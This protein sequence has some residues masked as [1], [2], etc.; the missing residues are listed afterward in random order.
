M[1]QIYFDSAYEGVTRTG[2]ESQPYLDPSELPAPWT[3]AGGNAYF[4]KRGSEWNFTQSFKL[5]AFTTSAISIGAYGDES[6]QRPIIRCYRLIDSSEC[7]EVSLSFTIGVA[8]MTTT[9]ASGTNLWRVPASFLGLFEGD[10]WGVAVDPT[11]TIIGGG[12]DVAPAAAREYT[13]LNTDTNT[14]RVV[15]SE[16]NPV[17]VYGGLYAS[18]MSLADS[19]NWEASRSIYVVNAGGGCP[20]SDI[21][22]DL[23]RAPIRFY[24]ALTTDT[25]N[26]KRM[27]DNNIIDCVLTRAAIGFEYACDDTVIGSG[28]GFERVRVRGNYGENLGRSFIDTSSSS[29]S[30]C[31]NDTRIYENVCNGFGQSYSTGG[32]YLARVNTT[33]G[34]HVMVD[35]NTMSGGISGN[36]WPE[37]GHAFYQEIDSQDLMFRDNFSWNNDQNFI[38][39]IGG[40]RVAFVANVAVAKANTFDDLSRMFTHT[41]MKAESNTLFHGNVAVGLKN[42]VTSYDLGRIARSAVI[43]GNVSL[44]DVA[45]GGSGLTVNTNALRFGGH[46]TT[47]VT[48]DGNALSGHDNSWFDTTAW[49]AYNTAPQ[50][51]NPVAGDFSAEVARIPVPTDPTVNYALQI[52]PGARIVNGTVDL[53]PGTRLVV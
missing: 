21:Q 46:D 38:C 16:G 8:A 15:Y 30:I 27:P 20:V 43:S 47:Y 9:P 53:R 50:I 32:I 19:V 7:T 1:A 25:I 3:I 18:N 41:S 29:G 37:D 40:R 52:R 42:L 22:F 36:I 12:D 13:S 6:S 23:C 34:S 5:A 2:S 51:N 4:F 44:C 26:Y 35:R 33:D 11:R 10:I 28:Y 24:R 39:Y 14:Y 49:S 48:V 31:L 17:T 45:S